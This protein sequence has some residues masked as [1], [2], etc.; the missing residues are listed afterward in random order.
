MHYNLKKH[1][2]IL[3]HGHYSPPKQRLG[4]HPVHRDIVDVVVEV[5]VK[6]KSAIYKQCNIT[7][8]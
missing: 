4:L 5:K 6:V 1:N 8:T 7:S 3:C 2:S